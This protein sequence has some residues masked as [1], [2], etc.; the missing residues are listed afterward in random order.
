MLVTRSRGGSGASID[1]YT[2]SFVAGHATTPMAGL[3]P[4]QRLDEQERSNPNDDHPTV[5]TYLA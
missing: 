4:P 2:A 3:A 5:L 1:L